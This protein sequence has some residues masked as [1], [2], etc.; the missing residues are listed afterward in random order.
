MEGWRSELQL[1]RPVSGLKHGLQCYRLALMA[2]N[3]LSLLKHG[4]EMHFVMD[5]KSDENQNQP[6][7]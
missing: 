2:F 3:F 4:A 6:K 7:L 1:L 5:Q